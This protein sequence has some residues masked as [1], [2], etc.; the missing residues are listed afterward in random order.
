MWRPKTIR[1]SQTHDYVAVGLRERE[2]PMSERVVG[3]EMERVIR[4]I[5]IYI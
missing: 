2:I 5:D 4:D 1:G 3:G